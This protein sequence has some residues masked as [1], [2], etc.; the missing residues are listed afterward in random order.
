M[1]PLI[2]ALA[3]CTFAACG[4]NAATPDTATFDT[5]TSD[6]GGTTPEPR[7]ASPSGIGA[8]ETVTVFDRGLQLPM[9]TQVVPAGWSLTQDVAV[10]PVTGK[11]LRHTLDFHGPDGALIRSLG[12]AGWTAIQGTSFDGAWR[13]L[14]ARGLAGQVD[15]LVFDDVRRSETLRTLE[16]YRRT[17]EMS[18]QRGI[19]VDPLEISFKGTHGGRAVRGVLYI[20][21]FG[22]TSMPGVGTVSGTAVVA[23]ADRLPQV[24]DRYR[25]VADGYDPDPHYQHAR[26]RLHQ[27]GLQQRQAEHERRMA[28]SRMQHG[29]RMAQS[30]ARFDAHQRTMQDRYDAADA[31]Y[32]SWRS[33]QAVDDEMHRRTINGIHEQVDVF[34]PRYGETIYG[35]ESGYDAYWTDPAGNVVGTHGWENPDPLRYERARN[36]DEP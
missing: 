19:Q 27:A 18:A 2:A 15:A 7:A 28:A 11:A 23:A 29:Q 10:D 3:L 32:Q 8:A 25:L 31:R 24:L 12:T 4:P 17:A 22:S 30:Q 5:A 13:E 36:L 26:E 9:G 33:N 20:M 35:V 14:A 1:R 16:T 21:H 34:D 6:A